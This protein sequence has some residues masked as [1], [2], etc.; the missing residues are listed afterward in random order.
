[1]VGAIGQQHV[2]FAQVALL[3]PHQPV[4]QIDCGGRCAI[5]RGLLQVMERIFEIAL[6]PGRLCRQHVNRRLVGPDAQSLLQMSSSLLELAAFER[7]LGGLNLVQA[8]IVQTDLVQ[9]ITDK[10]QHH[11]QG[12]APG[13]PLKRMIESP[14]QP[15]VTMCYHNGGVA[16]QQGFRK[17][18][19]A[20]RRRSRREMCFE[21]RTVRS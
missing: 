16:V 11:H 2:S 18:R 6:S 8:P 19:E 9:G 3:Q 1:M 7:F 5:L 14:R 12:D 15:V 21:W 13:R 4:F 17:G 10:S 20:V